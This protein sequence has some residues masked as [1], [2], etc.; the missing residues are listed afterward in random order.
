MPR[1]AAT[2]KTLVSAMEA[3]GTSTNQPP[4]RHG[5][6]GRER[7]ETWLDES[8]R[9]QKRRERERPVRRRSADLEER[10]L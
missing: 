3:H 1:G 8:G 2:T 4:G 9:K 10:L 6:R 5:L 7:G